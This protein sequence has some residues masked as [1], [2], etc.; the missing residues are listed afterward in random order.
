MNDLTPRTRSVTSIERKATRPHIGIIS[1]S[2][3]S[4]LQCMHARNIFS[5]CTQVCASPRRSQMSSLLVCVCVCYAM[6]SAS[7]RPSVLLSS[8]RTSPI[9]H[10]PTWGFKWTFYIHT[11]SSASAAASTVI[12]SLPGTDSIFGYHSLLTILVSFRRT[13]FNSIP[14]YTFK[15]SFEL[16]FDSR[17]PVSRAAVGSAG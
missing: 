2:T 7:I 15:K 13:S 3:G 1:L 9:T 5:V 8:S 6:F 12:A 4:I 17:M 16:K 10:T 14:R 11:D